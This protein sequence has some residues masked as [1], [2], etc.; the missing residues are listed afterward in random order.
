MLKETSILKTCCGGEKKT[1]HHIGKIKETVSQT[2]FKVSFLCD[3]KNTIIFVFP[4]DDNE[5][6][7]EL[8]DTEMSSPKPISVHHTVRQNHSYTFCVNFEG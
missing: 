8:S 7:A 6:L 4:D 1:V 2:N 5:A 3:V